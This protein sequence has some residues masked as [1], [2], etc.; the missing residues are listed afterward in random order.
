MLGILAV[1]AVWA[2]AAA[3][4]LFGARRDLLRARSELQT[5]EQDL[6]AGDLLAGAGTDRIRTAAAALDDA[7]DRLDSPIFVPVRPLPVVGR[8]FRSAAALTQAARDAV[9]I[10]LDA[11]NAAAVLVDGGIPGSGDARVQAL[12]D[13][14]GIAGEAKRRLARIDLGP[15][16]ALLGFLVDARGDLARELASIGSTLGRTEEVSATLATILQGPSRFLVLGA[17]SAQMQNGMGMP[18]SYGVLE[19]AD[20]H[21]RLDGL[22]SITDLPLPTTPVARQ[23]DQAANWQWLD[24]SLD[25]RHLGTTAR[26]SATAQAAVDQWA[27]IGREPVDGVIALDPYALKPFLAVVGPLEV[28]GRPVGANDVAPLLLHDQYVEAFADGE[29]DI[30]QL[31]RRDQ[32][33]EVA[34]GA[35][36]AFEEGSGFDWHFLAGLADA[37]SGRHL[38]AWSHDPEVQHGFETAG[39]AGELDPDELLLSVINRGG[40]KLDWFLHSQ[41]TVTVGRPGA[42]G[43]RVMTVRVDL[44]N[45][46]GAGE[47]TYIAGPYPR[48][49]LAVGE[50]L[51]VATLTLPGWV[52]GPKFEGGRTVVLGSDGNHVIIGGEVRVPAGSTTTVIFTFKV[53]ASVSAM[54]VAPS[55]RPYPTDWT[56]GEQRWTDLNP[57]SFEVPAAS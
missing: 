50:Y 16:H 13:V 24:P 10:G 26:F 27:A 29:T 36:R 28:D 47:P 15:D 54:S 42:D 44:A 38:L 25:W 49:G 32:L 7:V 53:P 43:R 40:N 30:A 19:A 52:G 23:P 22:Q 14:S 8:Q 20:G 39:I 57:A 33:S 45:E 2:V 34:V 41:A 4:T 48:S 18:L 9:G 56:A 5:L 37:G 12:R 35:V 46:V 11:K 3:I 55:A 1:V 31:E 6:S 21:I 17:N 51:G